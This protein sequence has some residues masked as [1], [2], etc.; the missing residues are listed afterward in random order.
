MRSIPTQAAATTP[1]PAVLRGS[2][3]GLD[4][5][6][7]FEAPGLLDGV[8]APTAPG[9]ALLEL[10][11]RA[12]LAALWPR[13]GAESVVDAPLGGG[14]LRLGIERHADAGWMLQVP[15][16]GAHLISPTGDRVRSAPPCQEPWRW[17]RLLTGQVLPL[18]AT[19]QGLEVLHASA[20]A[21]GGGAVALVGASGAGKTSL[22]IRL[23]MA[24]AAVVS[25]DVL[26]LRA[27]DGRVLAHPGPPLVNVPPDW[28]ERDVALIGRRVGR[29]EAGWRVC[30]ARARGSLPLRA[31]FFLRRGETPSVRPL[32]DVGPLPLLRNIFSSALRTP[33]RLERQLALC[34]TVAAGV[35]CFE[36]AVAPGQ[37]P[38][39]S[40]RL[41]AGAVEEVPVAA[42]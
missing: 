23:A 31:V 39:E 40:A 12:E 17:Q 29:D 5:R 7:S 33:K 25:D 27:V 10:C 3:F 4:L 20:V 13:D 21:M 22:A 18:A 36:L 8:A 2:A 1:R 6:G 19:L 30:V 35:P 24:G 34:A 42:R 15:G 28:P 38:A 9:S 16:W 37:S 32:P 11:G 26:A 14:G 41:V